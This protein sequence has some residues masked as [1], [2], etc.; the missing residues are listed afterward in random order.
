LFLL[1][2]VTGRVPTIA[3]EPAP[4]VV[5]GFSYTRRLPVCHAFCTLFSGNKGMIDKVP[6]PF[7]EARHHGPARAISLTT[8]PWAKLPSRIASIS[9]S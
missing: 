4:A 3:L 1:P 8:L 5:L 2:Y 9:L 6:L 7:F